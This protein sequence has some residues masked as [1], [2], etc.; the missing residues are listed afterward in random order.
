MIEYIVCDTQK[1]KE[2]YKIKLKVTKKS[3]KYIELK[4]KGKLY[5]KTK[6]P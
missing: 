6:K 5:I 4:L 1:Y 3:N 2:E